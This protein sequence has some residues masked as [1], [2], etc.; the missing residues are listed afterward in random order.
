MELWACFVYSI[1]GPLGGEHRRP[2]VSGPR[3]VLESLFAVSEEARGLLDRGG[4]VQAGASFV[5]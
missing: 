2:F 4:T 1:E 5:S 3:D